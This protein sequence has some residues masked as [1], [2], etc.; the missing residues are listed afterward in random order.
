MITPQ[1]M[2]LDLRIAHEWLAFSL[3]ED[4]ENPDRLS[5]EDARVGEAALADLME[6]MRNLR[7]IPEATGPL[8]KMLDALD[9]LAA[10]KPMDDV[11]RRVYGRAIARERA[12]RAGK[13]SGKARRTGATQRW[14]QLALEEARKIRQASPL[15]TQEALAFHL[16]EKL[17]TK[18]RAGAPK[19]DTLRLFIRLAER[20]GELARRR[21]N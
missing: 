5:A 18:L 4:R 9:K 21:R 19:F 16:A 7:A 11:R 15:V 2:I 8:I 17:E 14:R 10:R 13:T 1:V 20:N 6:A 12:S 3:S